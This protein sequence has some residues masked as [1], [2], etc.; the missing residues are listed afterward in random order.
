MSTSK[1]RENWII[2][3]VCIHVNILTVILYYSCTQCYYWEKLDKV[4]TGSFC[5]IPTTAC[6]SKLSSIKNQLKSYL[7][8]IPEEIQRIV[9]AL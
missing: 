2:L 1:P 6:E 8:D 5:I 3:V 4:H 7:G 9:L